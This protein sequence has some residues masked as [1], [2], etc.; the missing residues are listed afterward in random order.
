M[1]R[2][3]AL[4]STLFLALGCGKDDTPED[5]AECQ[6]EAIDL[7]AC[8][9]S[10]LSSVQSE[11]IWNINI[12]LNDNSGT[13]SSM[14][15]S[16]LSTGPTMLG[17]NVTERRVSEDT[18]FL[19]SETTDSAGGTMRYVLAGC[20]STGPGQLGGIFRRCRSGTADLKGTFEAVRLQRRAGEEESS[21]VALVSEIALP[22]G[23]PVE[24][25]V[26]HGHAYIAA[27]AEGLFV[28]NVSDPA[29]PR[30]VAESKPSSDFYSDLV[31][32]GQT[33]YVA[34]Q[35]SGIAVFSLADPAAPARIRS[36]PEKAV[37]VSA[38][39]V[40]GDLLFAA[41]PRPNAEVLVY[42]IA[43]PTEPK[44][45]TRYF[46]E[47]SEPQLE[48]RPLDVT[49]AGGR[50]YVSHWSYGLTVSDISTPAKPKLL[51]RFASATSR[52]TAVG[53][54]GNRM[55]A[56]DAGEDWNAHLRVLD[57][58]APA[59]VTQVGEFRMRPEVSIK[60]LALSGTK[61]YVA[62]YQD[63]LRVL[64]V[65][66]PGE[67]R[68]LGY[69]NT[70]RESDPGRGVSFLEGLNALRVPG[71]G[72]VYATDTSRGLLIFRETE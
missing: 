33:L 25:A 4:S 6:V 59:T 12:L 71:D 40:D 63:G 61:L 66:V 30:K 24:L 52:T 47:G 62:Y 10:S 58:A 5:K 48:E 54:V 37:E 44:L 64:D 72:Y 32:H 23:T 55:L 16:G 15:L 34:T 14:R 1:R 41:S 39:S 57:V 31:V 49:A 50:L 46:V 7:S 70:W 51:G 28:Y 69:Y 53:T 17:F 19:A 67:I 21:K 2:L 18:F 9:R 43:T 56:F 36:V 22:R 45:V 68:Q 11:G 3:F 20:S 42:N 8:Q 13:A 60:A 38:V 26:A 27:G 29:Q 35:L 65:S